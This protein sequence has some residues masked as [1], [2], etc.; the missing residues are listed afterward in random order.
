MNWYL[1]WIRSQK[2]GFYMHNTVGPL[3]LQ[4]ICSRTPTYSDFCRYW[5]PW[6]T[7]KGPVGCNQKR[8][9]VTPNEVSERQFWFSKNRKCLSNTS[10][11]L[12]EVWEAACV[13]PMSQKTS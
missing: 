6:K 11:R 8:L 13:F 10:G 9:W 12:Y 7:L 2:N 1:Q 4:G 5:G 3:Y